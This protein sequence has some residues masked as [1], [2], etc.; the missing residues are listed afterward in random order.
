MN[1]ANEVA[2]EAFL[3]ARLGFLQ[4]VETVEQVMEKHAI[5]AHPGLDDLI[6]ADRDT[7][8]MRFI[9]ARHRATDQG[10]IPSGMHSPAAQRRH[11]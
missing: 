5:V 1:A 9:R 11:R 2:V 10:R 3:A 6:A 8:P 4:I 7:C